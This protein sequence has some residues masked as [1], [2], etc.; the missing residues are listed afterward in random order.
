MIARNVA[1]RAVQGLVELDLPL[2]HAHVHL[3]GRHIGM[4]AVKGQQFI[5]LGD[6]LVAESQGLVPLLLDQ[7]RVP[8][9]F[10]C[11][12]T[13]QSGHQLRRVVFVHEFLSRRVDLLKNRG[14][15]LIGLGLEPLEVNVIVP[16]VQ[17]AL[18][19]V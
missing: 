12:E 7:V 17:V 6:G 15:L 5:D 16:M 18:R 11:R 9:G 4:V 14:V 8:R 19:F 10:L 3:I 13:L 1:I 2:R